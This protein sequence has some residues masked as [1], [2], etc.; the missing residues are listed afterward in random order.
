MLLSAIKKSQRGS[1]S[2]SKAPIEEDIAEADE[3]IKEEEVTCL[4]ECRSL[5]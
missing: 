1:T 3:D 2:K 5:I 4:K